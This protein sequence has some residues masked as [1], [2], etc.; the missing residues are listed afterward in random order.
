MRKPPFRA[1][2]AA[3]PD[4]AAVAPDTLPGMEM[5]EADTLLTKPDT[6]NGA[7]ASRWYD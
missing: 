1:G 3:V 2:P 5:P 4:T 7:P 6:V